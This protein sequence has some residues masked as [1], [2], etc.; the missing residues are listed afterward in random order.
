MKYKPGDIVGPW[1]V[2]GPGTKTNSHHG[3]VYRAQCINCGYISDTVRENRIKSIPK[4]CRHER[5]FWY[6]E[7]LARCYHDMIKR[8]YKPGAAG[9]DQYG[10]RGITVCDEWRNDKHAFNDWAIN[11]GYTDELT[12]DRIDNDGNYCPENCRWVTKHFNFTHKRCNHHL[13]YGGL[14][15]TPFEWSNKL[16]VS[17]HLFY[18]MCLKRPIEE[19]NAYL[20]DI[21]E[22]RA[23]YTKPIRKKRY[24]KIDGVRRPIKEWATMIGW[25][26]KKLGD[27]FTT[28]GKKKCRATIK[29]L[30]KQQKDSLVIRLGND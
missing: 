5:N 22:G 11:N 23:V 25:T 19:V 24:I 30:L 26:K 12:I 13:T 14:T 1:K 3:P 28:V 20:A 10:A 17:K 29:K 2:L 16:G 27:H 4:F 9:Y 8:C 7:R 15:M 21:I 18:R 6:S